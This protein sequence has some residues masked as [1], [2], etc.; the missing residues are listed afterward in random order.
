[1]GALL[2]MKSEDRFNWW[3][4][5]LGV[6]AAF[7]VFFSIAVQENSDIE[8]FLFN[9]F[10]VPFVCLV[11][12]VILATRFRGLPENRWQSVSIMSIFVV[13][14]AVSWTLALN[15]RV[16]HTFARWTLT[17][18]IRKDQVLSQPLVADGQFRHAEWDGWGFAG[19][20]TVV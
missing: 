5:L 14:W 18:K 2:E 10:V 8:V 13:F 20:D 3:L 4:P 19:S 12:I 16:L 17:S 9:L 15:Y 1:M 6:A 11:L 7:I